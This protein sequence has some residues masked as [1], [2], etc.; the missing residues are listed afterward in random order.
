[1]VILGSYAFSPPPGLAPSAWICASSSRVS[2]EI[3]FPSL[4]ADVVGCCGGGCNPVC[5]VLELLLS[6]VYSP[7]EKRLAALA[8]SSVLLGRVGLSSFSHLSSSISCH[9]FSQAPVLSANDQRGFIFVHYL[10]VASVR[11][12]E[13]VVGNVILGFEDRPRFDGSWQL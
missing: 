6:Y 11:V 5:K 12:S 4:P 13:E 8:V 9:F 7:V 3:S 10:H 1:M 2:S